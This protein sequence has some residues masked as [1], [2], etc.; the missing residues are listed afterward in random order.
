MICEH[1][2]P[3]DLMYCW[4]IRMVRC[5]WG[6]TMLLVKPW[7]RGV[8]EEEVKWRNGKERKKKKHTF[9]WRVSSDELYW[10]FCLTSMVPWRATSNQSP[11]SPPTLCCFVSS[12]PLTWL[13]SHP[14]CLFSS[15]DPIIIHPFLIRR[16]FQPIQLIKW[17][18]I[19]VAVENLKTVSFCGKMSSIVAVTPPHTYHSV[20]PWLLSL[21]VL[22]SSGILACVMYVCM[23]HTVQNA[24]VMYTSIM[25]FTALKTFMRINSITI[26]KSANHTFFC[27]QKRSPPRYY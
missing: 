14:L 15:F 17:I 1:L 27:Q 6:E 21:P 3:P 10:R 4:N 11:H 25:F 19:F 16:W 9:Y 8:L 13:I 7:P 18:A 23:H 12:F 20:E 22:S 24:C 26:L 2:R 5:E